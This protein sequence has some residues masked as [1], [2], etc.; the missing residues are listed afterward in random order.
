[1]AEYTRTGM[2]TRPKLIEPVQIERAM[3]RSSPTRSFLESR[4]RSRRFQRRSRASPCDDAAAWVSH[5]SSSPYAAAEAYAPRQARPETQ[6]RPVGREA[7]GLPAQARLRAD[8]RAVGRR[9]ESLR[10]GT[11]VRDPASPRACPALRL[12]PGD[13]RGARELGGAQGR[14]ARPEGPAPRGARRRPSARLRRL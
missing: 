8:A 13:R 5:A 7:H 3:T 4:T 12:P 6:A 11:T 14:D 10:L 1:M 9:R 2:L